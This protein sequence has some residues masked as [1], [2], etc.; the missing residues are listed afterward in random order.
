[1]LPRPFYASHKTGVKEVL[2]KNNIDGF[3]IFIYFSSFP[4]HIFL[5]Q[6]FWFWRL[7][8]FT[9]S[10]QSLR[11]SCVSFYRG[12]GE[13]MKREKSVSVRSPQ[14]SARIPIAIATFK[15]LRRRFRK[16][17][18]SDIPHICLARVSLKLRVER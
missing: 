7:Q 14:E 12:G 5:F 17:K 1:M 8:N 6:C 13:Q 2:K 10:F 3:S 16:V 11:T 15:R 9:T 18:V 4:F